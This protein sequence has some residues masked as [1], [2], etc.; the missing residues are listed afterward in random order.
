MALAAMLCMLLS[1]AARG[2][3]LDGSLRVTII[4]HSQAT[5]EDAKVTVENEATGVAATTTASSAGTY[6]FPNLLIGTYTVTVEKDGFKKSIQKGIQVASN[7]VAETKVELELG[8]VSAVVEVEAGADLVKTDSSTLEATFSGKLVNDMP[9]GTLGG[10]V[11]EFAVFTPGTTTQQGGVLGSGGS[12]GGTRP[13]F[14]GFS[15][16]GVDDNRIDVNGPVQPVIQESVA[17]FTLLTNQFGAEYGHSAGGLF[18]IVT[19]SGPTTGTAR[20]G[21]STGTATTTRPT[22]CR[23]NASRAVRRRTR[24]AS[25][26]TGLAPVSAVRLKETSFSFTARMNFRTKG[27]PRPVRRSPCRPPRAF[28]SYRR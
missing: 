21:S 27:W 24:I 11:K 20:C 19:K 17:E 26:T 9:I 18:N 15:I 6:V 23:R 22:T 7:Q 1:S 3:R 2:Q 25:T 13:R 10:D 28:P 14:N 12:I 8:S 4:D 5:I 16:D